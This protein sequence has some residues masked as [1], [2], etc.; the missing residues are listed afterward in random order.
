MQIRTYIP[1]PSFFRRR[2]IIGLALLL[3]STAVI[4]A[5][6]PQKVVVEQQPIDLNGDW[7]G[8][9]IKQTGQSVLAYAGSKEIFH[10]NLTNQKLEG[11]FVLP[12]TEHGKKCTGADELWWEAKLT[13]SQNGNT[14][15]IRGEQFKNW[16]SD[17]ETCGNIQY[18]W[19]TLPAVFTKTKAFQVV[20]PACSAPTICKGDFLKESGGK[21]NLDETKLLNSTVERSGV[22]TDGVTQLLLRVKGSESVTFTL[23]GN[24]SCEFGALAKL[25]GT[26]SCSSLTVE[27]NKIGQESYVFAIYNAPL[28]FPVTSL[29]PSKASAV[30]FLEVK[31]SSGTIIDTKSLQLQPPPIMLVHGLWDKPGS[32]NWVF[33][34]KLKKAGYNVYLIDHNSGRYPATGT[35]DPLFACKETSGSSCINSALPQLIEGT[36]KTIGDLRAKGIAATQVD[37]V[38]HSMGG[39][40]ARAVV[41]TTNYGYQ[42][43]R[44][45]NQQ[46]GDFHKLITIGTPHQ[47]TPMADILV[48]KKCQTREV[49]TH[50]YSSPYGSSSSTYCYDETIE[51]NLKKDNRQIGPAVYGLQTGSI[52][53]KNIGD[54]LSIFS[55]DYRYC[56]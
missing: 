8:I 41:K 48:N 22:V 17:M 56:P 5:P 21:V 12:T 3:L 9:T 32:W 45:D 46:K 52:A 34:P 38:G 13:V 44:L 19:D 31:N 27:P 55:C 30:V 10:G 39:L 11:E 37:V 53:I 14:Q 1:L 42:Y 47:G 51:M 50:S 15:T 18:F 36:K 7:D 43:K 24:E 2:G 29:A 54:T 28:N 16:R 6:G 35:F 25:D 40:I 4:A 49:C 26:S 20:D 23:N 33:T